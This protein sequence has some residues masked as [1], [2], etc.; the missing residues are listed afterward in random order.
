MTRQ[1][2]DQNRKRDSNEISWRGD[3]YDTEQERWKSAKSLGDKMDELGWTQ[4]EYYK[5]KIWLQEEL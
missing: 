5:D 1:D 3:V 2:M 4:Q